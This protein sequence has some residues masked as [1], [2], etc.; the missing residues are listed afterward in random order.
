MNKRQ[1]KKKYK[2]EHGY[3]PPT[4]KKY[5]A[6]VEYVAALARNIMVCFDDVKRAIE[7]GMENIKTMPE[8]EFNE[9]L[10]NLDVEQQAIALKIRNS[11]KEEKKE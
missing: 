5:V 6:L 8:A 9:R 1:W 10:K 3:N 11:A 2:K 7:L 4:S